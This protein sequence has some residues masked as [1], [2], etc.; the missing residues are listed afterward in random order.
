MNNLL[1]IIKQLF[2]DHKWL[3]KGF[4][5]MDTPWFSSQERRCPKCKKIEYKFKQK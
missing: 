2:C 5:T 1:K 3:V 4:G